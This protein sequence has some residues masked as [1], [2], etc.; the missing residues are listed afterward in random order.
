VISPSQGRNLHT[1]Q[2]KHRINAYTHQISMPCV[3]FEPTIPAS[4]RAKTVHA[5]DRAAT[6][7]SQYLHMEDGKS[8]AAHGTPSVPVSGRR[9]VGTTFFG[10]KINSQCYIDT[11]YKHLR[12]FS[13]ERIAE[14]W[15]QQYSAKC[16]S[17]RATMHAIS[18]L[19]GDRIISK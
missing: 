10:N 1:G 5:L 2:H 17:A 3:G 4:E 11:F 18:L 9:T 14:L 12:H 19:F 6:V 13:E 16:H 15:L 8:H 7:I